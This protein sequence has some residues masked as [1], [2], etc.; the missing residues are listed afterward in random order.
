MALHSI[1]TIPGEGGDLVL[2]SSR[3][4]PSVML[5]SGAAIHV[6]SPKYTLLSPGVHP[7][8]NP[9]LLDSNDGA[10]AL[11]SRERPGGHAAGRRKLHPPAICLDISTSSRAL[12]RY[13]WI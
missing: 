9:D 12:R 11:W 13:R 8:V 1:Y 10:A 7:R 4:L 2:S 3:D 5:L 6:C